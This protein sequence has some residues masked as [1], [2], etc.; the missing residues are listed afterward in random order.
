[1]RL[2]INMQPLGATLGGRLTGQFEQTNA[3]APTAIIRIHAGI[4]N[5]G[6]RPTIPGD[7]DEADQQLA[8]IGADMGQTARK[9]GGKAMR[10]GRSPGHKPKRPQI[11]VGR[12]R[13]EPT[14][15]QAHSPLRM[16]G[17]RE[18]SWAMPSISTL[19]EPIIQS[20]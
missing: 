1:M 2:E 10:P 20:M 13:I 9:N 15:D 7:V 16:T 8:I 14:V 5:E 19:S 6:V 18:P 4:E 11:V 17:T 3:D 12:M